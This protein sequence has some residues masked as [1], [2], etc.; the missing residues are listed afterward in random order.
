VSA[1][2]VRGS[3][4]FIYNKVAYIP[5][6]GLLR[7]D[8][9]YG[10]PLLL[11]TAVID[12]LNI[13]LSRYFEV[14]YFL[15]DTCCHACALCVH[16][17]VRAHGRLSLRVCQHACATFLVLRACRCVSALVLSAQNGCVEAFA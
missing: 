6:A 8:L 16:A 3:F 12:W 9:L 4:H 7:V 10:G 1:C 11:Q 14:F 17:C 13:V 5:I 2:A 15:I